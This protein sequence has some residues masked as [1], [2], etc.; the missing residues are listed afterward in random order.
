MLEA[1]LVSGWS[2]RP[3]PAVPAV[4]HVL[5]CRHD[6]SRV[7]MGGGGGGLPVSL[8]KCLLPLRCPQKSSA[9]WVCR[10]A[11]KDKPMALVTLTCRVVWGCSYSVFRESQGAA[12]VREVGCGC[13]VSP[14]PLEPALPRSATLAASHG[15]CTPGAHHC[16]PFPFP[17]AALSDPPMSSPGRAAPLGYPIVHGG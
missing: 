8:P 5:S 3:L 1:A 17:P 12:Q 7:W 16:V 13:R 9:H 2:P 6:C 11:G 14:E 4:P 15:H 10:E